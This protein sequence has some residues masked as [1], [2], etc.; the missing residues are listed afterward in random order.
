[1]SEPESKRPKVRSVLSGATMPLGTAAE[2]DSGG[3]SLVGG[4]GDAQGPQDYETEDPFRFG[5]HHIDP[6]LLKEL[7]E[8]PLQRLDEKDKVTTMPPGLGEGQEATVEPDQGVAATSQRVEGSSTP[9]TKSPG[10]PRRRGPRLALATVGMMALVVGVLWSASPPSATIG[11]E[12]T[13]NSEAPSENRASEN[14]A[15]ENGPSESKARESKAL[16]PQSL[17]A[18]ATPPP[19]TTSPQDETGDGP[20]DPTRPSQGTEEPLQVGSAPTRSPDEASS[21]DTPRPHRREPARQAAKA[22]APTKPR[23]REIDIETPITGL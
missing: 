22:P 9:S 21:L 12:P 11:L 20:S 8:K 17:T 2:A 14:R 1:M 4:V 10:E 3:P 7:A 5:W 6:D 19:Q 23:S 15:S 18:R 16:E 13:D